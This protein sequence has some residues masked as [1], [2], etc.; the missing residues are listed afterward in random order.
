VID[1]YM[2]RDLHDP[3]RSAPFRVADYYWK[4]ADDPEIRRGIFHDD[5]RT[6][7]YVISTPQLVD[8]TRHNGFPVVAPA[9][10]HSSRIAA[11]D[12]GGWNVEI[13]RVDPHASN[14]FRLPA[15]AAPPLPSCMNYGI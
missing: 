9:L 12:S 10:E 6:V 8:D 11:F 4:V 13:R 14:Q 3:P 2:W 7:D 15:V 1:Q 5:W